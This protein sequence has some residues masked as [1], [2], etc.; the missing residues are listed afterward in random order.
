VTGIAYLNTLGL[1][2]TTG[3]KHEAVGIVL[4]VAAVGL[5]LSTDQLFTFLTRSAL[6]SREGLATPPVPAAPEAPGSATGGLRTLAMI[7]TAAYLVLA[8]GIW[9]LDHRSRLPDLA[10]APRPTPGADLLPK[11][12]GAWEQA[13]FTTQH[14]DQSSFFGENSCVWRYTSARKSAVVSL[15]YPFPGWHDLT[16]CYTAKGWH[17]DGQAVRTDLPA[18]GGCVEVRMSQSAHRHA[19]LLFREF[20]NAG[21]PFAARPGGMEASLFRHQS[22]VLRLRSR[23]GLDAEV[24]GDPTGAANQVQVVLESYERLTP[25][26]EAA[27]RDLF[28][29]ASPLLAGSPSE[30]P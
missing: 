28:L 22:T 5:L 16:W 15:D 27:A 25:E 30:S 13:E 3:W 8:L 18:P 26:D 11:K 19:Y 23:L 2:L 24:P 20:D 6:P 9:V 1:D 14:R 4:F 10:A 29:A 7:G 17:I 12:L 21:R